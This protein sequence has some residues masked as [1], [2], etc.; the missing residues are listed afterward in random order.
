MAHSSDGKVLLDEL[1]PSK[2]SETFEGIGRSIPN[3]PTPLKIHALNS[4]EIVFQSNASD[5][6]NN[7]IASITERWFSG[8]NPSNDLEF[9]HNFCRNPFPEIKLAAL[10]FLRA[11]VA[12]QWG[13][14]ALTRT[15]GLIEYL[16][17]RKAEFD[18]DV[19]HEKYDVVKD[20]STSTVFDATIR[21]QIRQYVSVGAFYVQGIMDVAVEGN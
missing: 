15:A 11:V 13:Q 17:D 2:L 21:E 1:Y 4:L 18:K 19:L 6:Q 9:I 12:Y 10:K 7:Q 14:I 8:L 20:L 5:A 16:L 3:L